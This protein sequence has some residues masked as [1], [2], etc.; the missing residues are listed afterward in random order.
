MPA[1]SLNLLLP[2]NDLVVM[3]TTMPLSWPQVSAS[4]FVTL[5]SRQEADSE[6]VMVDLGF[7]DDFF[8]QDRSWDDF[9]TSISGIEATHQNSIGS[10]MLVLYVVPRFNDK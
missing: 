3:I 9:G 7:G 2:S 4:S 1:R 6:I 10:R 5:G 8:E